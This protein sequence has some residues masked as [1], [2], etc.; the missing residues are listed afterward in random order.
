MQTAILLTGVNQVDHI[1]QFD[2]LALQITNDC[3]SAVTILQSRDCPNLKSAIEALAGGIIHQLQNYKPHS[4]LKRNCMTLNVLESLY[5]NSYSESET[6]PKLVIMLADFEQFNQNV[7]QELF[8]NLCLYTTRLPIVLV[9]G[10]ATAYKTLH[11]VLPFH[12]TSK[13]NVSIFQ[14]EPSTVM[15][16]KILQEVVLAPHSTFHLS[17]KSFKILM[18]IFLFYDY[19]LHSFIQGYKIF[20]LEHFYQN[21]VCALYCSSHVKIKAKISSMSHDDFEYIRRRCMSFRSFVENQENPQMKIDLITNDEIL[22]IKMAGRIVRIQRHWLQFYCSLRILAVLIG[23]LPR[24]SLGKLIR[25]IYPIAMSSDI[26][27]LEEFQECFKLLQ[28]SSK[29][30]ILNKLNVVLE[31]I[32]ECLTE[33]GLINEQLKTV[34]KFQVCLSEHRDAIAEAG[35]S[36]TKDEVAVNTPK[37]PSTEINKT[38]TMGRQ[39]MM[40]KLKQSAKNN[41]TRVMIPYEMKLSCCLGDLKRF[42]ELYLIPANKAPAL[43]ELFVFADCQ[44]VRRQIVG[45]PRGA[46]HMALSNPNH[47]LQC[48]C[49][50]VPDTERILPSLPDIGIAYKLHLECNKFINLYDWLQA[51]SMVIE[52]NDNGDDDE[53]IRPEIQYVSYFLHDV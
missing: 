24:N 37:T 31:V 39:E 42:F 1:K 3:S 45:A 51:F 33:T 9:L 44:S 46:L 34:R 5:Q 18:D 13:I 10:I 6:K 2:S 16:N 19:S 22:R 15:L 20:M 21:P 49:C 14:T 27:K 43:Y 8:N 40:E 23:D 28:F 50:T 25:E 35:M 7:L 12:I 29:D 32:D 41:P 11:N 48:S 26:T 4:N 30:Q 38:G 36:P 47:Y 53:N 17:G 52:T